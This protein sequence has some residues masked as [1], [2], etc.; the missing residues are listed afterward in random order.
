[1]Q[2][3]PPCTDLCSSGNMILTIESEASTIVATTDLFRK[4]VLHITVLCSRRLC[5]LHISHV[6][7]MSSAFIYT[8]LMLQALRKMACQ[9]QS[10]RLQ[11]SAGAL[12]TVR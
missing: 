4:M 2:K 10:Q 6:A 1:M 12:G 7:L 11:A 3:N 5:H 9:G 8:V